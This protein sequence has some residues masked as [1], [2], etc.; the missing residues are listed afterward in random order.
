M[1]ELTQGQQVEKEIL[2]VLVQQVQEGRQKGGIQGEHTPSEHHIPSSS[3]PPFLFL[4]LFTLVVWDL[5]SF[6]SS[7]FVESCACLAILMGAAWKHDMRKAVAG[8]SR[9]SCR[10]GSYQ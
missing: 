2:A 4:L 6:W 5:L 3:S 8:L 9:A 1:L 10:M 7:F